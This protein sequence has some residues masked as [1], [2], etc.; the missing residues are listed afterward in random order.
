PAED[1]GLQ[2]GDFIVGLQGRSLDVGDPGGDVVAV[3]REFAG[4]EISLDIQRGDE[5]FTVMLTP[6][7]DENRPAIGIGI[8]S[9]WETNDG[10][11]LQQVRN[12]TEFIPQSFGDSVIYAT[13]QTTNLMTQLVMLPV[14]LI[15]GEI[16]GEEARPVSIVGISQIGGAWLQDSVQRNAPSIILNFIAVISIA[17]GVTNLLPLPPLDG[18]RI[19]FVLIEIVRG[20]PVSPEIENT[21]YR[22]GIALLL[23]LG[24]IVIIFDIVNPIDLAP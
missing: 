5:T 24:V 9:L 16:S 14:Q 20:K 12:Q 19:L 4:Q 21:V 7:A 3:A 18:G 10:S 17:L 6:R 23:I 13:R 11:V 22:I 8:A 1:A 2:A 15:T